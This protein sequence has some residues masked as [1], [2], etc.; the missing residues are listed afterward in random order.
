MRILAISMLFPGA[1]LEPRRHGIGEK[2]SMYR[3]KGT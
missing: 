2:Y 3:Q 1:P